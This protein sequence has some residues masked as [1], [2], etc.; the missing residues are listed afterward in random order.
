MESETKLLACP[1]CG[2]QPVVFR[3]HDLWSVHCD[4]DQCDITVE[5]PSS[6]DKNLAIAAWNTRPDRPQ[7]EGRQGVGELLVELKAM[8]PRPDDGGEARYNRELYLRAA[9]LIERLTAE[10]EGARVHDI[11]LG[12][13]R[14]TLAGAILAWNDFYPEMKPQDKAEDAEFG[15][16]YKLRLLL[17]RLLDP[18]IDEGVDAAAAALVLREG[19]RP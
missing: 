8:A 5:S 11:P 17:G 6:V 16:M 9:A 7:A 13:L 4:A 10:R 19:A 2:Q 18:P 14:R 1:F 3:E 15:P 12:E